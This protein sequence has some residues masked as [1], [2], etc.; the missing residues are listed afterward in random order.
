MTTPAVTN[1]QDKIDQSVFNKPRKENA[2]PIFK[3]NKPENLI[4]NVDF[5]KI[6]NDIKDLKKFLV[7]DI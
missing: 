5:D 4:E 2:S 3:S 6:F 1:F 7:N